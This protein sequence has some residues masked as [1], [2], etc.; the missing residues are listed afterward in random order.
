MN[1]NQQQMLHTVAEVAKILHTNVSY[2]HKLRRAGL[3]PVIKIGCWK[4]RDVDLQKFLAKYI[5]WDIS[6]PDHPVKLGGLR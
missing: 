1:D 5:G 4:V 6:D 3:L 2:V